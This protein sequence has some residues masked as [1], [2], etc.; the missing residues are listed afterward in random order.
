MLLAV[1]MAILFNSHVSHATA[2]KLPKERQ[3]LNFAQGYSFGWS[4]TNQFGST[5]KINGLAKICGFVI[6]RSGVRVS[7]LA[8]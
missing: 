4:P 7:M 1:G 6:S 8:P 3:V 2:K 5:N